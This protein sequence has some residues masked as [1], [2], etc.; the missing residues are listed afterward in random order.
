MST[1][2][3]K[4]LRIKGCCGCELSEKT[5]PQL[6][7][8]DISLETDFSIA[9]VSDDLSDTVDYRGVEIIIRYIFVTSVFSTI[10]RLGAEITQQIFDQ[11]K[12]VSRIDLTIK[13]PAAPVDFDCDY[14]GITF[15]KNR[16]DWLDSS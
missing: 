5:S 6:F 10:E 3:V 2:L 13:K 8:F 14:V 11:F 15:Q 9:F 16:K 12:T 1:V 7:V 4:N